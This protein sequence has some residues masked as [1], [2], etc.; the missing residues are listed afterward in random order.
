MKRILNCTRAQAFLLSIL[1]VSGFGV[2][3]FFYGEKL[4]SNALQL[5]TTVVLLLGGVLKSGDGFFFDGTPKD[6]KKP[7]DAK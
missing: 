3:A 1:A 7:E 5:I 4:S 6:E 2:L